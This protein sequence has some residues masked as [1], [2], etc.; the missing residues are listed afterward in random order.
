MGKAK[1][2]AQREEIIQW[3][4]WRWEFM[5]RN[6]KVRAAYR[7]V[8]KLRNRARFPASSTKYYGTAEYLK[9][10][11]LKQKFAIPFRAT[12]FPDPSKPYE[13][14][15]KEYGSVLG[16]STLFFRMNGARFGFDPNDMEKVTIRIDFGQ[17]N[18]IEDLKAYLNQKI[19]EHLLICCCASNKRKRVNKTDY[20]L[21]LKIGQLREQGL[22]NLEIAKIVYPKETSE[23][24]NAARKVGLL[25]QRFNELVQ[26]GYDALTFP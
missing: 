25:S 10:R 12:L 17:V 13:E 26:G 9:E 11:E 16:L 18:S 6:P 2:Q 7:A 21:I 8:L 20:D 19:D 22:S 5:R 3:A 1:S 4:R 14:I 24:E 23:L 15:A